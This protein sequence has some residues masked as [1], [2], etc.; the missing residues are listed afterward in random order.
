MKKVFDQNKT[1]YCYQE[2]KIAYN[3]LFSDAHINGMTKDFILNSIDK[4]Y[5]EKFKKF[6][7]PAIKEC[8]NKNYDN[9][10]LH[11]FIAGSYNELS[12]KLPL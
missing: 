4:H 10:I 12:E 11:P 3:F 8:I 2:Q 6:N 5:T 1:G 7:I 9:Y